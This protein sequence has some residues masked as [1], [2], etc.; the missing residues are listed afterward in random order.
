MLI[1][2]W[3]RGGHRQAGRV[4]TLYCFHFDTCCLSLVSIEAYWC[5]SGGVMGR[6]FLAF[7]LG[8]LFLLVY[9]YSNGLRGS[10]MIDGSG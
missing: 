10:F 2:D 5:C 3:M 1:L 7:L 4:R 6:L 8:V 9:E